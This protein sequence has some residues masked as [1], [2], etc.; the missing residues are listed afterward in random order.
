MTDERI[1]CLLILVTL[2]A[3]VLPES[4]ITLIDYWKVRKDKEEDKK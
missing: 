3:C 2:M 1:A 4:I